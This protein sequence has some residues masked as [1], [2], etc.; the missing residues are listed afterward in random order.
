L[1]S[2]LGSLEEKVD[3][4]ENIENEEENEWIDL[5]N[6]SLA[7]EFI[8]A[9]E[10]IDKKQEKKSAIAKMLAGIVA[11]FVGVL[12]IAIWVYYNYPEVFWNDTTNIAKTSLNDA[13]SNN[14][15]S[16]E[17][18][19]WKSNSKNDNQIEGTL[20]ENKIDNNWK[21]N[22][23]TDNDLA[24][25]F[26]K[27]NADDWIETKD[28]GDD[29]LPEISE[30]EVENVSFKKDDRVDD[31]TVSDDNAD[32]VNELVNEEWKKLLKEV[33]GLLVKNYM[34]AIK[35]KDE[36]RKQIL[37][38][39]I[40]KMNEFDWNSITPEMLSKLKKYKEKLQQLLENN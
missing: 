6:N 38:K 13:S 11:G 18:V 2:M 17:Q 28:K 4:L 33:K 24:E 37:R 1:E 12:G 19:S 22:S 31:L 26:T 40:S 25:D 14:A 20:E 32:N 15:S 39:L 7:Q 30:N 3:S 23:S 29:N 21:N 9:A 36:N 35:K 5:S 10:E 8:K 16:D 27:N 34:L